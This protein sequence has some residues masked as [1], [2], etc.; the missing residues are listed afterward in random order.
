MAPAR[1][2]GHLAVDGARCLVANALLALR[3]LLASVRSLLQNLHLARHDAAA[4]GPGTSR[5]GL[6][7]VDAV[8]GALVS[9]TSSL[10][11]D[12]WAAGTA[13]LVLLSDSARPLLH[14]TMATL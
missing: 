5:P 14:T 6:P 2:A 13:V 3:A 1:E 4:T 8:G 9:V 7:G 11:V 10:I 12:R